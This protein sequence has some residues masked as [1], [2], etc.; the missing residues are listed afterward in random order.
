MGVARQ[1]DLN[2][3]TE[4]QAL[5][6]ELEFFVSES[7]R[8]KPMEAR[9]RFVTDQ[10]RRLFEKG[11]VVRLNPNLRASLRDAYC[12][13]KAAD[14]IIN[15]AWNSGRGCNVWAINVNEASARLPVAKSKAK[16]ACGALKA[17][18]STFES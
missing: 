14:E 15:V 5:L 3:H 17:Y 16:V 18:L 8:V 7:S 4:L 1:E 2:S 11:I 10:Y 9:A 13:I 12:E 6:E